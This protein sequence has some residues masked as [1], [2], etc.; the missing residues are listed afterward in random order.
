[1]NKCELLGRT[2]KEIDLRYTT[3]EKP[4]AVARFTLAVNRKGK[5]KGADFISCV[6]FGKIA[7]TIDRYIGKGN[8]IASVGHIQTGSYDHKNGY[9]VYTTDVVVDEMTFV[10]S[11]NSQSQ[12]SS[13]SDDQTEMDELPVGFSEIEDSDIP[14]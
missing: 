11:K 6:A 1:M 3:G 5:D 14:F 7:E 10:D 2:T 8:R 4:M 9:K 13:Q 12:S